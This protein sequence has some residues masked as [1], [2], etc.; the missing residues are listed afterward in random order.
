MLGL[1]EREEEVNEALNDLYATGCRIVTI[2]QYLAPSLEHMPVV[3]YVT[4]EKSLKNTS[5]RVFEIVLTSW[6]AAPLVRSSFHAEKH[7]RD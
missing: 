1:G 7:V 5:G 6:K 3:E 2:G 4:P